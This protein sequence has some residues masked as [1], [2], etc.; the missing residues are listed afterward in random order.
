[1]LVPL[2]SRAT[3]YGA[4]SSLPFGGARGRVFLAFP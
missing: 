4:M 2:T 1:M 3:A